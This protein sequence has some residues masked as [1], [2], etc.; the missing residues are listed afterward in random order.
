MNQ[1]MNEMFKK[2]LPN[3]HE[4]C[5]EYAARTGVKIYAGNPPLGLV[6]E[7][8]MGTIEN[9]KMALSILAGRVAAIEQ[10]FAPKEEPKKEKKS[11]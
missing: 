10:G 8:L 5:E 4:W 6:V 7:D 11:K 9:M 2:D 3:L 1:T